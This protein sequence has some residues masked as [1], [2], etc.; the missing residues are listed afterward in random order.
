MLVHFLLKSTVINADCAGCCSYTQ[1]LIYAQRNAF[2]NLLF[3]IVDL[4]AGS[5]F[6][7]D[8]L[9]KLCSSV[10]CCPCNASICRSCQVIQLLLCSRNRARI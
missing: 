2:R 5:L 3:A 9:S 1:S 10:K 6:G 8:K 4:T 7:K